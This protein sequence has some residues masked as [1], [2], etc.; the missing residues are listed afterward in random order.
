M[1]IVI[2]LGLNHSVNQS[3]YLFAKTSGYYSA[4][5]KESIE[6]AAHGQLDIYKPINH[7]Y[8]NK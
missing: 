5:I 8:T 4:T 1:P 3:I 6:L 2:I 7:K